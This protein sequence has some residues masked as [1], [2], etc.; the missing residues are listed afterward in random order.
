[1]IKAER[2]FHCWRDKL[3]MV[4]SLIVSEGLMSWVWGLY[5]LDGDCDTY[6]LHHLS[7]VNLNQS[8]RC[9]SLSL[10]DS[11]SS[12]W[13]TQDFLTALTSWGHQLSCPLGDR[14]LSCWWQPKSVLVLN[15]RVKTTLTR[16]SIVHNAVV[17]AVLISLVYLC[18]L[19]NRQRLGELQNMHQHPWRVHCA[20]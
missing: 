9:R 19:T 8:E 17:T 16:F 2:I 5:Q 13:Y 3:S 14:V 12:A 7:C 10:H 1:M 4:L 15:Q 6:E 11:L 20:W 18:G